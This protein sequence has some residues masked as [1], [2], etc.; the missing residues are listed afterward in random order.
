LL[1]LAVSVVAVIF[2][3]QQQEQAFAKKN[4]LNDLG[5]AMDQ[6]GDEF[7]AGQDAGRDAFR[8]TGVYDERCTPNGNDAWCAGYMTGYTAGWN[9]LAGSGKECGGGN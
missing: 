5:N 7:S 1:I 9:G 3:A 8:T 2:A 4:I 6:G